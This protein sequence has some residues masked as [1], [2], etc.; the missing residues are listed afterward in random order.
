MVPES[1]CEGLHSFH[2][3]TGVVEWLAKF[4]V[5]QKT[6]DDESARHPIRE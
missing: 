2:L 4:P 5:G 1:S 6:T 3:L